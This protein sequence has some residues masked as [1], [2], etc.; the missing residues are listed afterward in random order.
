MRK[1]RSI[2]GDIDKKRSFWRRV[3]SRSLHVPAGVAHG[4]ETN[5]V[6]VNFVPTI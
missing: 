5:E 3:F 2:A 4:R 6:F 1:E